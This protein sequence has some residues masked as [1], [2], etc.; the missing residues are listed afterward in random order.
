[1]ARELHLNFQ[2]RFCKSVLTHEDI[3]DIHTVAS[4]VADR[5]DGGQHPAWNPGPEEMQDR[6]LALAPFL[7]F[8]SASHLLKGLLQGSPGPV[9]GCPQHT[10]KEACDLHRPVRPKYQGA[11]SYGQPQ[12]A[13]QGSGGYA[14]PFLLFVSIFLL[15]K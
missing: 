4:S 2:K 9:S 12:R 13:A 5:G 8:T 11:A 6:N 3:P 7:P 15:L 10:Q 14:K 1:M